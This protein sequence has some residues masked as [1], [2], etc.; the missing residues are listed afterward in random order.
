MIFGYQNVSY[1]WIKKVGHES[2]D[3]IYI[4]THII[5]RCLEGA[6]CAFSLHF[7]HRDN[8]LVGPPTISLFFFSKEWRQKHS[9]IQSY[10]FNI[11]YDIFILFWD[12]ISYRYIALE[13]DTSR[14]TLF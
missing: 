4:Y 9:P 13:N 8:A 7:G 11:T 6:S 1:A 12:M 14:D 3:Y 2:E 5:S 10:N